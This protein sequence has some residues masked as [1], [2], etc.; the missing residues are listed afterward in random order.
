ML[1]TSAHHAPLSLVDVDTVPVE[2]SLSEALEDIAES[3]DESR[4]REKRIDTD[5]VLRYYRQ[6]DRVYRRYHSR[7]GALHVGLVPAG[8]AH[9]Q[10]HGHTRQ[11]ELFGAMVKEMGGSRS[12]EFGCGTGYNIRLLSRWFPDRQW[13]GVD[14]SSDHILA[15]TRLN[16]GRPNSS[17]GVGNYLDLGLP[18]ESFDAILA[19]ETLCQSES[20]ERAL[21]EAYRI[22]RPGGQMMVIDCFRAGPLGEL[23]PDL[24]RAA[25]LVE[26]TAAVDAFSEIGVWLEMANSI[27]FSTKEAIDRSAETTHDL[28]RLYRMARRFF[29]LH[30]VARHLTRRVAPRALQNVICGLL[31]PYTVGEGAHRY[32]SVVL[33]KPE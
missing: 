8:T 12:L 26:K 31:M 9:P 27:G 10:Q 29:R 7:Q 24:A 23:A 15:A 20:Q 5:E 21:R 18:P 3:F 25:V 1:S 17:F 11:A 2:Q 13:H 19:V 22:L 33:A 16:E 30:P 32:M 28:T 14:L 6:C 4:I